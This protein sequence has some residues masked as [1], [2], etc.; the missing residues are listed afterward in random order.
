LVVTVPIFA[1]PTIEFDELE[2]FSLPKQKEEKPPLAPFTSEVRKDHFLDGLFNALYGFYNAP[3]FISNK[4][5][6]D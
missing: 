1:S 4:R 2:S 5:W 6:R 3:F